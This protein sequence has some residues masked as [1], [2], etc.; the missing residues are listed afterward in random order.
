VSV[1][2]GFEFKEYFSENLFEKGAQFFFS[3][4]K[5]L[6]NFKHFIIEEKCVIQD[7]IDISEKYLGMEFPFE[8]FQIVFLPNLFL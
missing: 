1:F 6:D 4:H 3:T 8:T 2:F 7:L 5:K